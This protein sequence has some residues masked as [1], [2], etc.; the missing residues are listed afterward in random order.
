MH[1]C[2]ELGGGNFRRPRPRPLAH[3]I[4][5]DYGRTTL[6]HRSRRTQALAH[7]APTPPAR[8]GANHDFVADRVSHLRGPFAHR[9]A[10]GPERPRRQD[11]G[12]SPP[13]KG[14]PGQNS[15]GPRSARA[16]PRPH[17]LSR[18]AAPT[19]RVESG[20][21]PL[22]V[23][24]KQRGRHGP[25]DYPQ[26][27]PPH[28]ASGVR[29]RGNSGRR[30]TRM[31]H[32]SEDVGAPRPEKLRKFRQCITKSTPSQLSRRHAGLHRGR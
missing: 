16:C 25:G 32:V 2:G 13:S 21:P 8:P 23:A 27:R 4:S 30:P 7:R 22:F 28:R 18:L 12:P 14:P 1:S 31:P 11:R 10:R 5:R 9:E 15:L 6:P 3:G 24:P 19:L 17:L 29:R 26:R 20:P